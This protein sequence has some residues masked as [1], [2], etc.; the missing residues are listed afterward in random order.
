MPQSV[1]NMVDK[2]MNCD[3]LAMNVLVSHITRKPPIK[4]FSLTNNSI[5]AQ[6]NSAVITPCQRM[7]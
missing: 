5:D 6:A 1:R 3:D 4:V 7:M 2:M